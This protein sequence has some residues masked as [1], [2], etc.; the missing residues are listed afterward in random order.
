[1]LT[2][3]VIKNTLLA[4]IITLSL[5]GFGDCCSSYL[6]RSKSICVP[7]F[8]NERNMHEL[9]GIA[10]DIEFFQ[11]K[12]GRHVGIRSCASAGGFG[13]FY[14]AGC[15]LAILYNPNTGDKHLREYTI[16]C[17]GINL[18]YLIDAL[19]ENDYGWVRGSSF[20]RSP[21]NGST[22]S[23]DKIKKMVKNNC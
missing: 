7:D 4:R 8:D 23:L 5:D 12:R 21:R 2:P 22:L 19:N 18:T 1:M 15:S 14:Q 16:G 13:H 3:P 9:R 20:I 17:L 10:G 6:Y 11:T